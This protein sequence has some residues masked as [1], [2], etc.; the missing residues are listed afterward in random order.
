MSKG[1]QDYQ[2]RSLINQYTVVNPIDGNGT[3]HGGGD[4]YIYTKANVEGMIDRLTIILD[5]VD[6]DDLLEVSLFVDSVYLIYMPLSFDYKT[7]SREYLYKYFKITKQDYKLLQIVID[8]VSP[9]IFY[10]GYQ[11]ILSGWTIT[12]DIHY[13]FDIN[14]LSRSPVTIYGS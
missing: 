2:L 12:N 14:Y 4:Q 9:I 11:L 10:S 3:L 5:Y 1:Y 8:L 13:N 7:N 6:I